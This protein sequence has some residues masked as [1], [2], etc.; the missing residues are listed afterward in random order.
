VP[1]T[2]NGATAVPFLTA[3]KLNVG[4]NS[5]DYTFNESVA[6]PFA[7]DFYVGLSNGDRVEGSGTPTVSGNTV[8]VTFNT[9]DLSRQDEYAVTAFTERPST[10]Q[11][12]FNP[13]NQ[14]DT[15]AV[16]DV[17]GNFAVPG[18]APIGDN[19][20]AF[21]RGFTTGPDVFAVGANPNGTV[22]VNLDQRLRS[23]GLDVGGLPPNSTTGIHVYDSS[24]TQFDRPSSFNI[25]SQG[26]GPETITLQFPAADINRL[27][28]GGA[29]SFSD[30][31]MFTDLFTGNDD[32]SVPQVVKPT[33]SSA[34]LRAYKVAKKY[35]A[36]HKKHH[37]THRAHK[38]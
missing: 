5:V 15:S 23:N 4:Q 3:A 14:P 17:N 32:C 34:I 31:A 8:H 12:Q 24:A 11:T 37:K 38:R 25:P 16:T 18:S 36:H 28:T 20:G 27:N 9:R 10:G 33:S 1:N 6:A 30:C 35:F 26:A 19:A 22:I 13:N 21:G 29:L 7:S 2:N